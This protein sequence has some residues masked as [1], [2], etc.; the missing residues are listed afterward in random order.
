VKG[1]AQLDRK[2]YTLSVLLLWWSSVTPGLPALT[3]VN[4][5]INVSL[6]FIPRDEGMNLFDVICA[7]GGRWFGVGA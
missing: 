5:T 7:I 2:F 4:E 1:L 6:E 3:G